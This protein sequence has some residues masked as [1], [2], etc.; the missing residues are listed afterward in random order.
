MRSFKILI[1]VLL[2]FS[3]CGDDFVIPNYYSGSISAELNGSDW[4]SLIHG[5]NIN[6]SNEYGLEL[7]NFNSQNIISEVLT[8]G[9]LPKDTGEFILSS[10]FQNIHSLYN[11]LALDGDVVC[12]V[13]YLVD[14]ANY[15]NILTISKFENNGQNIEGTFKLT[16]YHTSPDDKCDNNAPDTIKFRNVVF[17]TRITR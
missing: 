11:T 7:A 6:N 9:P 17:Q 13:Y 10:N 15:Q 16:F 1:G 3:S 5:H 4:T 12:D 2:M 14:S 8:F